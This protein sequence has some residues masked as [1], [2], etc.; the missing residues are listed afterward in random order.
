MSMWCATTIRQTKRQMSKGQRNRAKHA[1]KVEA[2]VITSAQ[3]EAINREINK[4]VLEIDKEYSRNM[5]ACVLYV[6]Y[7]VFGYGPIRLRRF[8]DAFV[9][10]HQDL[11]KRYEFDTKDTNWLCRHKL[12]QMGIDLDQ[13]ERE[14]FDGTDDD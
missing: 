12:E 13:W 3:R 6:L 8:Y 2:V 10:T 11:Q 7:D 9:R 4:R 14:T 1:A 5:E